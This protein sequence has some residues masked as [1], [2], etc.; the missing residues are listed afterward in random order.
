MPLGGGS[1]SDRWGG[2][3]QSGR[4]PSRKTLAAMMAA[5][6]PCVF[7]K[8]WR[9]GVEWKQGVA[10]EEGGGY[11]NS[12]REGT[13]ENVPPVALLLRPRRKLLHCHCWGGVRFK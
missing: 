1:G 6:S 5:R 7:L 3:L 10:K 9:G 8:N 2:G 4:V 11:G 12:R 13:A